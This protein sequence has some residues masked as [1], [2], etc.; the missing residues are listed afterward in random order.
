MKAGIKIIIG[1][2]LIISGILAINNPANTQVSRSAYFLEQLPSSNVLNPA[3]HPESKFYLNLPV[4]STFYLG[5]E[6]PFS[7]DDLTAEWPGGDSLYIDREGVLKVLNSNNYFSFE[8]Y[9]ELGRSGCGS[10]KHYFHISIVKKFSTK[11]GF[12]KDLAALLL[13]GNAN[14]QFLGKRAARSF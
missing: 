2:L 11:F 5:F 12:Q 14:P 6:S 4:L 1:S 8:L 13:F 10:G 9:T 3:F 7:F